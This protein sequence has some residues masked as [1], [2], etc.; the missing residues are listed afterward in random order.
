MPEQK[1]YW[2]DRPENVTTLYRGVWAI[3]IALALAEL[4]VLRHEEL[5]FAGRFAF[6]ALFG[7]VACVALVLAAKEILRRL[8]KRPEDYYER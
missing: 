1:R 4:F 5:A 6:Y 7:F 3:G 8:V 2:L